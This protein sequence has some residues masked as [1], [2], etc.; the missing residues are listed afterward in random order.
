MPDENS[1]AGRVRRYAQVSTAAVPAAGMVN[2][3][4]PVMFVS[5]PLLMVRLVT[6]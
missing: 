3:G 5:V 6:P 1:I 4:L 2:V